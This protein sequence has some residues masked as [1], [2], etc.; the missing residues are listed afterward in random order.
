MEDKHIAEVLAQKRG[1]ITGLILDL[2]ERLRQAKQDLVHIDASIRIFNPD[3]DFRH[4][5]HKRPSTRTGMFAHGEIARH[6]REAMRASAEPVSAESVAIQIMQ[7]RQFDIADAKL[8]RKVNHSV[9]ISLREM[10]KAR[11]VEKV[12]EGL[13]TLWKLPER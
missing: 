9:L 3:A 13:G 8:R 1:A 12:G 11:S 4:I 7:V 5:S 2:E 10:R 6:C